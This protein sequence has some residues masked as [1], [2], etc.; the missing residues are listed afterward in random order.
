MADN[1]SE[2]VRAFLETIRT[3]RDDIKKQL[4]QKLE[5]ALDNAMEDVFELT[6]SFIDQE[7]GIYNEPNDQ[8]DDLSASN[9]TLRKGIFRSPIMRI[10]KGFRWL[11]LI[12]ALYIDKSMHYISINKSNSR[13]GKINASSIS[14][15]SNNKTKLDINNV[16]NSMACNRHLG[17]SNRGSSIGKSSN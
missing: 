13:N 16:T 2:K 7:S 11:T 14:I 5:K 8:I 6:C 9:G 17:D 12:F 10:E 15:S 4:S 3:R 1:P